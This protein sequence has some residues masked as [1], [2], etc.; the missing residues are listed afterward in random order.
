MGLFHKG[1]LFAKDGSYRGNCTIAQLGYLY[2]NFE[3]NFLLETDQELCLGL[4]MNP[5][6]RGRDR[7][8]KRDADRKTPFHEKIWGMVTGI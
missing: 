1:W 7:R 5:S 3:I 6:S 8:I 2:L 4:K